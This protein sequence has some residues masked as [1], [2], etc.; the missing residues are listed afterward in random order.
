[1]WFWCKGQ[2]LYTYF[3]MLGRLAILQC[4]ASIS[5]PVFDWKAPRIMFIVIVCTDNIIAKILKWYLHLMLFCENRAIW[6]SLGIPT[7]CVWSQ[8]ALNEFQYCRIC[9]KSKSFGCQ[10]YQPVPNHHHLENMLSKN[11]LAFRLKSLI[12]LLLLSVLT[13]S[14]QSTWPQCINLLTAV[15]LASDFYNL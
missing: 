1:M 14:L 11:F 15:H 6:S 7:H 5:E 12:V 8:P 10:T 2:W 13:S 3:L 4:D 9:L